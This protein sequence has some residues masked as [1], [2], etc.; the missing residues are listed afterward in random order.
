ME[1]QKNTYEK[2][3][4]MSKQTLNIMLGK[5]LCSVYYVLDTILS[6]CRLIPHIYPMRQVLL[7]PHLNLK[8]LRQATRGQVTLV[9]NHMAV[10]ARIEV[11]L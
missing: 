9:K 7:Y 1:A 11:W 3:L 6:P 2:P 8:K 4:I 5:T 10:Y